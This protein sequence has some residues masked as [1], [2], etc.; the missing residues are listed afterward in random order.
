MGRNEVN[1]LNTASFP[2][3]F[4]GM[5]PNVI[6]CCHQSFLLFTASNIACEGV[7]SAQT[8]CR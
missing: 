5:E 4:G 8:F 6:H 7:R 1:E 2:D 3:Y